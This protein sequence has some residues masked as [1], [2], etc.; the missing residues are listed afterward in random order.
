MNRLLH[1]DYRFPLLAAPFLGFIHRMRGEGE[2]EKGITYSA[3]SF[4]W[5]GDVDKLFLDEI[6]LSSVILH[7]E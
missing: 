7:A 6:I 2:S 3:P 1:S 4:I 5:K